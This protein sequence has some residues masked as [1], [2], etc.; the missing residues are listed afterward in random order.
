MYTAIQVAGED[1][2]GDCMFAIKKNGKFTG[3][4]IA[5]QTREKAI[6]N[7]KKFLE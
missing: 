5:A 7:Y 6:Q 3:T 1:V 2:H 4:S